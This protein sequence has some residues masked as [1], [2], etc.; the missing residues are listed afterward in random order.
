LGDDAGG[1]VGG[2]GFPGELFEDLVEVFVEDGLEAAGDGVAQGCA[3]IRQVGVQA[4]DHG[5]G[6]GL[7][8]EGA[9]AFGDQGGGGLAGGG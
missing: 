4:A 1:F 9:E 8:E 3:P 6:G 2:W 5:H 7:V